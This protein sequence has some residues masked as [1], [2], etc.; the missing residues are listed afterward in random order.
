MSHSFN[1]MSVLGNDA[2]SLTD[3]TNVINAATSKRDI[4]AAPIA[5]R[6]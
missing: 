5:D 2:G 6:I 3:C 1:K 4:K